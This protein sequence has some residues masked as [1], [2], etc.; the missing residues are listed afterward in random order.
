M[1]KRETL[2]RK[3]TDFLHRVGRRRLWIQTHDIPDPD[4]LASAEAFR[5][6][7]AHFGVGAK[8]V[9]NGFPHRRENKVLIKECKIP[10]LPLESVRI[11]AS[12]RP[13]WAFIDCLPGGGNVTLHPSAPGDLFFAI[14]HHGKPDRKL[15]NDSNGLV[16]VEPDVGA[17]ASLMG[18][19]LLE[20]EVPFPPRLASALS[21]A[22]IT[23]T[24]DF[25]RGVSGVDLEVYSALFPFTNQKIISRLRNVTKPRFYFT[26][27][28]RALENAF[29]YRHVAW[30]YI[31]E[32]RT[33]ESVAEMADFIL[34]CERITWSLALGHTSDRL[35]I[36]IRSSQPKARC[37]RVIHRLIRGFHGT[38]GGHN[39]FAGGFVFLEKPDDPDEIADELVKRFVRI[40]LRLPRS[41]E[42]PQGT[43][44]VVTERA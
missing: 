22:I 18:K 32:V 6:V 25:S 9:C 33:G 39:E 35:Y 7:A 19:V 40:T 31:G 11:R 16:V 2:S 17:T 23:D 14:D 37:A 44:F 43:P 4:A 10:L 21:Y 27:V 30:A 41:A 8:I 3:I 13:A 26:T 38:V 29:S 12:S 15:K 28:H 42:A 5:V 34:S 24:Q 36:S 1:Q 20:L